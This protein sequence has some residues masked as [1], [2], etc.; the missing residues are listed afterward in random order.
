MHDC[1]GVHRL[2]RSHGI[3][4]IALLFAFVFHS[5]PSGA[6]LL[7]HNKQISKVITSYIGG[8]HGFERQFLTGE[9][10]VELTPQGTLAERIRAGG[11][12]IP[13]F[14]TPTA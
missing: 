1:A 6:D 5:I 7:L 10:S 2:A 12:G 3:H 4:W 11:A 8:N 14:F 13:A 9:I